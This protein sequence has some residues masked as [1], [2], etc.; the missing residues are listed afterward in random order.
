[1]GR[2]LTL[3]ATQPFRDSGYVSGETGFG[4]NARNN[5]LPVKTLHNSLI[6]AGLL[7]LAGTLVAADAVPKD[8]V[9]AAAKK[10]AAS[11]NYSWHTTTDTGAGGGGGGGRMRPG[12][13]DGRTE[14]DGI[15]QLTMSRGE[16]TTE[17]FMKGDKAAVK[18]PDGWKTLAEMGEGGGG[19]GGGQGNPGRFLARTLQGYKAPAIEAQDLVGKVK[20]LTRSGDALTGDLTVEGAKEFLT[21]GPRRGGGGGPETSNEKGSVKFWVKDGVLTKYELHVQ[22]SMSFNG[23]SRDIDRTTTVEIKDVGTTKIEVPE[24]AK[25][26]MS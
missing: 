8:D 6:L 17:A 20:D 22:G 12:P 18:T 23:E 15:T 3:R 10:L 13:T 2:S 5:L 25:K 21:R 9:L 14:K 1:M 19:G 7:G 16:T 24:D 4:G 11:S 26:K